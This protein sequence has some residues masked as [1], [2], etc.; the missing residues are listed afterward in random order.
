MRAAAGPAGV[1]AGANR[2]AAEVLLLG[3]AITGRWEVDE[4]AKR[5]TAAP[6]AAGLGALPLETAATGGAIGI[7]PDATGVAAAAGVAAATGAAHDVNG[8]EDAAALLAAGCTAPA[9]G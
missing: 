4:S 1:A 7:F 5:S 3:D 6:E 9:K 2:A 8:P